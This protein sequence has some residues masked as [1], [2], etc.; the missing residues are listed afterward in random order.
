MQWLKKL[1]N[2]LFKRRKIKLIEESKDIVHRK[3]NVRDNFVS[4]LKN[5]V[6]LERDDRNG[7]KIIRNFKLKDMI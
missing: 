6:D 3:E 5:T 4:M 7:Y 2:I 1:I